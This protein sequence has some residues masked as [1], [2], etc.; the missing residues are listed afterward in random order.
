MACRWIGTALIFTAGVLAGC[1]SRP[2]A[3]L[4][5]VPAGR[6]SAVF[7][8]AKDVLRDA[9]FELDRVDAEGGVITTRARGSS[10]LAT[11]WLPHS[12]G[13]SDAVTGLAQ[14]ERRRVEVVFSAA[15]EADQQRETPGSDVARPALPPDMPLRLEVLVTVERVYRPGKRVDATGVRLTSYASDPSMRQDG[16]EPA[17]AVE[18]R[19]DAGLAG[20]LAEKIRKSA[21]I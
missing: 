12:A 10:G 21:G 9:Q 11:P 6:Y 20:V 16:L 3:A 5:D 14:R 19:K 13:F 7:Q 18:S 8:A 4:V 15:G 1:A 17:F 2:G